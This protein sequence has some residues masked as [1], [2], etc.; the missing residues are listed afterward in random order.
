M[1]ACIHSFIGFSSWLM[2][3]SCGKVWGL[4]F[5]VL[6]LVDDHLMRESMGLSWMPFDGVMM[7]GES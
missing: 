4:G 1:N 3:A 6:E 7:M 5:R 2:I